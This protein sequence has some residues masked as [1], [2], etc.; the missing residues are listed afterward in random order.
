[1]F[2]PMLRLCAL[3]SV[4]FVS[5]TALADPPPVAQVRNMLSA[6]EGGPSAEAWQALGPETLTVLEQLYDDE[7]Q[8]PFVRLRAVQAAGHFPS[9]TSRAF[10]KRVATESG[11]NDL[12]VRAALRTMA[13]AFGSSALADIRPFLTHRTATIREGAVLALG[14]IESP[15]V[16]PLLEAR[17]DRERDATVKAT[18][19][20]ALR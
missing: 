2:L 13:R 18:L 11:Q 4:L 5:T 6:F 12:L 7:G 17:L 16:R 3:L 19:H 14:T 9:D 20:R 1:M 8:Q 15:R 10:L